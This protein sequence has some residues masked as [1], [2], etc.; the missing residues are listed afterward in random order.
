MWWKL[1]RHYLFG[2][3]DESHDSCHM[4]GQDNY[5]PCIDQA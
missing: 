5:L 2:W 4:T 3:N 1:E